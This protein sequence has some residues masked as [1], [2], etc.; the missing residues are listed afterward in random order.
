[1]IEITLTLF[2]YYQSIPLSECQIV[3]LLRINQHAQTCLIRY[4]PLRHNPTTP[5]LSAQSD[6]VRAV[7]EAQQAE[8]IGTTVADH[9]NPEMRV[10]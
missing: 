7:G 3:W 8:V 2:V 9:C 6:H 1:M 10:G 4:L 5:L